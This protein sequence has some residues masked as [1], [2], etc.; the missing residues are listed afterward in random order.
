MEVIEGKTEELG[1]ALRLLRSQ[2]SSRKL[3]FVPTMGY[4][5]EGHRK[6]F[7]EAKKLG[8]CALSIFVNPLQFND[9]EDYKNYPRDLEHDLKICKQSNVDFV[10]IPPSHEIYTEKPVLELAMPQLTGVL[11]GQSRPGH[12]EGVLL[13]VLKL[14]LL[15]QPDYALF[16]KKDYQQYLIIKAMVKDLGLPIKVLGIETVRRKDS[17]ALSSRNAQLS[18]EG[19]QNASLI[20][21]AL[22]IA[23]E[24]YLE[25]Q[26]SGE[27][28]KEI[29]KD[30]ILSG[31]RNN[32]DYIEIVETDSLKAIK[33]LSE[34][35][36]PF[37]FAVA[38]FCENVR[39]IDNLECQ[40]AKLS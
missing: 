16:G 25:G 28:L 32:I 15:F 11:C 8:L 27:E 36:T 2:H 23:Y 13:I 12:F 39:L 7:E 4:L 9:P 31:T 6:L 40:P 35:R 37:L 33:D 5:H 3:A 20:Y 34:Q 30:V 26:N 24:A 17:L 22:K 10:F 1:Q 21:R 29:I 19:E 38:V 18:P 14:F